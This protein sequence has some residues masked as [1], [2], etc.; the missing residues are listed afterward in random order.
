MTAR[1]HGAEIWYFGADAPWETL[2]RSGFRRRN[3]RLLKS[4]AEH[5]EVKR[6]FNARWVLRPELARCLVRAPDL[7]DAPTVVDVRLCTILPER[8]W[9]PLSGPLNRLF[10]RVQIALQTGR[11]P[12]RRAIIWCYWPEGF[13]FASAVGL[14]GTWVFDADHDLLHD[15]NRT[16]GDEQVLAGTLRSIAE[17]CALVVGGSRSIL[18]WFARNGARRV[19]RIRNG[20]GPLRPLGLR[21]DPGRPIRVAYAGTL[22]KWVDFRLLAD[23]A[24]ARP[25]WTISVAGAPH[26]AALPD[27]V[28]ARPN[29]EFVGRVEPAAL[30]AW[31]ASFDA[32]IGLY[33]REPWL[34]VD[35][36][37]LFDYLAAG[38]RVVST[39]YHDYLAADFEGLLDLASTAGEFVSAIERIVD[40]DDH[41][42][43][44]WDE[45]RCAFLERNSWSA[46]ADTALR[47][48]HGHG[49]PA[50]VP[51]VSVSN[52]HSL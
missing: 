14:A 37:K 50:L 44:D 51:M 23:I 10:Y 7:G 5:G 20:A 41:A 15:E 42:R 48:L 11:Q 21:R 13:R 16:A 28:A 45:R 17:R 18:E 40:E 27:D 6:V 43:R 25:G 8:T 33:R 1:A 26:G 19:G 32:A 12:D 49:E 30:P 36:M 35:S 52:A 24:V 3:T 46:R 34:D 31:L 4:F 47:M 22:S 9:L 2:T 38:V 29:I 39:P